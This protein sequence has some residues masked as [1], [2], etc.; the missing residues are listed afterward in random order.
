MLINTTSFCVKYCLS[1]PF[2]YNMLILNYVHLLPSSHSLLL[3]TVKPARLSRSSIR[4]ILL[5]LD[6][7]DSCRQTVIRH[8]WTIRPFS[9]QSFCLLFRSPFGYLTK[10]PFNEWSYDPQMSN[11]HCYQTFCPLTKW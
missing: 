2:T 10:R 3:T 4:N 9:Y 7:R 6:I 5:A 8:L 11:Y 1:N